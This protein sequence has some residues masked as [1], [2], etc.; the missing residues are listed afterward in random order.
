M[1]NKKDVERAFLKDRKLPNSNEINTYKNFE[2]VNSA[3]KA[4]Q[5]KFIKKVVL[6]SGAVITTVVIS[7]AVF[8][9]TK[10]G[11]KK[12]TTTI[13]TTTTTYPGKIENSEKSAIH[14]PISTKQIAYSSYKINGSNG[15]TIQHTTGTLIKIPANAF[16]NKKGK[17]EGDTVEVRYR[18]F[19]NPSEIFLS[20]IPMRYDSGGNQYNLETA[21]MFEI[22]AFSKDGELNLKKGNKIGIELASTN[23]ETKYNLY[24][25]DTINGN[26]KFMG[27]DQ[28]IQS[29]KLEN[30]ED[31]K[32][33]KATKVNYK[34]VT[35][36]ISTTTEEYPLPQKADVN[37]FTF[38]IDFDKKKFPGL[39]SYDGVEFQV[40]GK[41]FKPFYYK[42]NWDKITL[43]NNETSGNFVA[44]LKKADTL[45][46]V[47]VLPVLD[48]RN[49]ELALKEFKAKHQQILT[50]EQS[51][52]YRDEQRLEEVNNKI[53]SGIYKK[54][55]ED[56]INLNLNAT[57]N[58]EIPRLGVFNCDHPILLPIA[59]A[60]K[61]ADD[62]FN[63]KNTIKFDKIFII[64][65][66]KNTLYTF[67][68]NE[69]IRLSPKTQKIIWTVTDKKEIAFFNPNDFNFKNQA[70][71]GITPI[72]EK[73]E[74]K[75]QQIIKRFDILTAN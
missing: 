44:E 28:V 32:T 11:I 74:N 55:F 9:T 34:N 16:E 1:S 49:Y 75:A 15:G 60:I 58:F 70:A 12:N 47:D 56:G 57:R 23:S 43:T 72:I 53:K 40:V 24:E 13:T 18:E 42:I 36:T 27:K 20:G 17:S 3:L 41:N 7:T 54:K 37:K 21:G 48:E 67:D 26:W 71:N 73:D 19:H 51:K 10:A 52:T 45:I 68:K 64:E 62:R 59:L 5:K 8:I 61:L 14:P 4:N 31:T 2:Q 35:Q 69:P 66:G 46:K 33:T 6:A 22:R 63:Q 30:R 29:H 25:L 38:N 39:A 65:K 50:N